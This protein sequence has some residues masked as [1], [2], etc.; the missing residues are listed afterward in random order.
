MFEVTEGVLQREILSPI[1]FILYLHD[2]VDF[3]RSRGAQGIQTNN[4]YDLLMLL[5]ADDLVIRART[6]ND[7]KKTLKILEE[8][9]TR[10]FLTVNITKTKILHFRKGGPRKKGSL[11][12]NGKTIEWVDEYMYLGVPFT[13]ST[14]GLTAT[15][16][17]SQKAQSAAGVAL[18]TLAN[19]RAKSWRGTLRIYDA[20]VASTLLYASHLWGL[21]YLDVLEKS[22]PSFF[23]RL[24]LLPSGTPSAALKHELDLLNVRTRVLRLAL[25]WGSKILD[26]GNH[27]IS[28]ICYNRLL[29]LS[30]SPS[31]DPKYN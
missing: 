20:I 4:V 17:A 24:L 5:Y 9:C 2:I 14:L 16:V 26:M 22:Q 11:L 1:L 3:F 28:K 15:K 23:K 30:D 8:Y 29:Q 18:S 27:R 12:F 31:I 10:N 21:R 13:S 7:L 6:I 25:G 19:I